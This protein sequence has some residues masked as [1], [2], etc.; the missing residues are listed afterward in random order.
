MNVRHKIFIY[1]IL[2]VLTVIIPNT[3]MQVFGEINGTDA[4]TIKYQS[5]AD[6]PP[7]KYLD[8]HI[9]T[10]FDID[11]TKLIF[12][13]NDYNLTI[14]IGQWPEIYEKLKTSQID[15]A[16]IIAVT[17]ERKKEILYSKVVLKSHLAAYMKKN[18]KTKND[19]KLKLADLKNYRVGTGTKQYSETVLTDKLGLQPYATFDTV[20]QGIDALND[21]KIDVLFEIQ[22]VANYIL[23]KKGLQTVIEPKLSNLYPI[24]AAYGIS[25]KNPGLVS[26]INKRINALQKSGV[27]EELYLRYFFMH[28]DDY[29]ANKRLAWSS[30]L[31][32]VIVGVIAAFL[33]LQ[34][35][36]SYLKKKLNFEK[37]ELKAANEELVAAEIELKKQN[38]ELIRKGEELRL[39]EERY[40]LAV[41]GVNDGIWDWDNEKNAIFISGRCRAILGYTENELPSK[42]EAWV[43]IVHPDDKEK[44]LKAVESY[45]SGTSKEHFQMEIRFKTGAGDHKWVLIKGKSIINDDGIV[46]RVAGS[47]T[48]INDRKLAEEKIHQMAYYDNLTGLPNRT[49]LLDRFSIASANA[50]RKKRMVAIYFLDLDNFK[51]I[52]DTLGHVYG[53]ELI[54]EVGKYLKDQMRRGDTIARL[55][56]DEFII[57]QPNIREVGEVTR[58]ASRLLDSFKQPWMLQGREFYVTASIGITFFPDDGQEM[59]TLMKHADTA[60]YRAKELGKNNFQ[61]YTEALNTRMLQKLNMENDLRKA[62]ERNEMVIHYQPQI[63]LKTGRTVSMEALLRWQHPVNGMMNAKDFMSIAEETG[64]IVPIGEWVFLTAFSQLKKWREEGNNT[65]KL[66]INISSRQFMQKNLIE[67]ISTSVD[68]TGVMPQWIDLEV[69][70]II[71]FKD[72]EYTLSTLHS[73]KEMGF[74]IILDDFCSGYSSLNYLKQMPIDNIKIDKNYIRDMTEG[75]S[76]A[77]IVKA[78]ISLAHDLNIKVTA[79]G[80][81]TEDKLELLSKEKCDMVQ[82]YFISTPLSEDAV[83]LQR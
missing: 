24:K 28:S 15:T 60:M 17:D 12:L 55:G 77:M 41:D 58:M 65:I 56:G 10:G 3:C 7:F 30:T 27:Y 39:S 53:D 16:G 50:L 43:K 70:E 26:Y 23:I 1:A 83:I 11:F 57:M 71:A 35:Y 6:Y 8:S 31:I 21:G 49:L 13:K 59:Q 29:Y 82:G 20:E 36:I 47:L 32:L 48:D 5:E 45:L 42:L 73:I 75:S 66:S 76:E 81:E 64:L 46:T 78:L 61:L 2:I 72:L 25:K 54:S 68:S 52:N 19:D 9:L 67:T 22:E 34:L 33:L 80:V 4:E 79:E 74:G 62:L 40:R 63:E 14:S 38:D 44:F 18:M 37:K 51:T 69:N